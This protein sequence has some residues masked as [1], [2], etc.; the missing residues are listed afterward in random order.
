MLIIG[1]SVGASGGSI[2]TLLVGRFG[3]LLVGRRVGDGRIVGGG[4]EQR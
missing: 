4:F 2:I 1:L 3:I